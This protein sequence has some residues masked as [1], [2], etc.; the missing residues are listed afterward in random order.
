MNDKKFNIGAV[1]NV[2]FWEILFLTFMVLKLTNVIAWSCLV[3]LSP[4]IA[5]VAL[6]ILVCIIIFVID[7][8]KGIDSAI[9]N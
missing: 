1:H 3:V 4:L 6:V 7:K 9:F 8:K 2:T 5:E